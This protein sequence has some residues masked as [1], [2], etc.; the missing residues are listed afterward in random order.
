MAG[1][2]PVWAVNLTLARLVLSPAP[3]PSE[4]R[5][6]AGHR[7]FVPER[8]RSDR[9]ARCRRAR[10]VGSRED[11]CAHDE[12]CRAPG[13]R[14]MYH[15]KRGAKICPNPILIRLERLDRVVLAAI[16]EALDEERP[17]R[18]RRAR[19]Q[20]PPAG[21]TRSRARR[22]DGAG[23]RRKTPFPERARSSASCSCGAW[24][25]VRSTRAPAMGI[26]SPGRAPMRSCCPRS[27]STL[28]V[29]PAGFEP[30]ISTLK[31]SRPGPG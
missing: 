4:S 17:R 15:H 9:S 19:R 30:A 24:S 12:N 29:T 13:R 31:G 21:A 5:Q 10:D 28:M 1:P 2:C 27:F 6:D 23:A 7:S 8:H 25:A 14:C 3:D 26:A 16:A 18:R 22:S 11:R 20:A